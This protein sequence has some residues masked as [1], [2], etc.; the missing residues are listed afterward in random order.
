MAGAPCFPSQGAKLPLEA[1]VSLVIWIMEDV[2]DGIL[3][4]YSSR[5]I[6]R[7][8]RSYFLLLRPLSY[9]GEE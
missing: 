4:E 8:F 1:Y 7:R 3:L 9:I 5:V 2:A 6:F